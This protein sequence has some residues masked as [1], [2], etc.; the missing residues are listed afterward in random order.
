[1]VIEIPHD[2]WFLSAL[3]G[4][5]ESLLNNTF[6]YVMSRSLTGS[7]RNKFYC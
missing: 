3:S 1:M 6:H 2:E 4:T 5:A 7:S